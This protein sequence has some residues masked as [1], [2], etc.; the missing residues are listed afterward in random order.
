MTSIPENQPGLLRDFSAEDSL[1]RLAELASEFGAQQI[2][3]SASKVAQRVSEGRFYVACVGQFKR[4]K[5]TLINA[6]VG[7]SVLPSGVVPV[8]AIPTIIRFGEWLAARVCFQNEV[9]TDIPVRNVEDYVAEEKNPENAKGVVGV[10][11]FA[12][13]PLLETGM[14]LVDTPG[15]GSVHA[16]NTEAT[17]AFVPHIDAAILVIGADPPIS[18]DELELVEAIGREIQEIIFVLNKSDRITESD[19]AAAHSFARRVIETRLK[20]E[21]PA[22][23][24][25][26]AL[27]HLEGRGEERDWPKFRGTLEQLMRNSGSSLVRRSAERAL[28]RTAVQLACVIDEERAA[29]ERP[30]EESERRIAELRELSRNAEQSLN[31]L[32]FLFAAEQQRLSKSLEGRRNLFL[33]DADSASRKEFE[34]ALR[35]VTTRS[36]PR[37][38]REAMHAAQEIARAQIA[39]W[40]AEEEKHAEERYAQIAQ[41]FI[42]LANG[43]LQR[44]RATG[45]P[46][47]GTLPGALDSELGFRTRSR[48]YFHQLERLAAPASPFQSFTDVLLGTFGARG[49]IVAGARELLKQLLKANSTR[50][51]NDVDDRVLESRRRLEGEIRQ[52][53][54]DVSATADRALTHATEIRAAGNPAVEMALGRLDAVKLEV[55]GLGRISAQRRG[56]I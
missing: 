52:A 20:R 54:I 38:R 47:L 42:N 35:C 18:G 32:G 11:I 43:F 5:S 22:I 37:L 13:S 56:W 7:L 49:V 48:F 34:S 10:E 15:L 2:A 39:P 28:R 9:W 40:L 55:M 17:R 50:V 27:Q 44:I 6:L 1:R 16:G 53:L 3:S 25:V 26:S 19:R 31:E 21:T 4:G 46:G 29:L 45:V 12:P 14:C 33:N 51:Q 24:E 30:I 23:F 8:T 41:R 36:G